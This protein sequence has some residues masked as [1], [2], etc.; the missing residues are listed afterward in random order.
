MR[1]SVILHKYNNTLSEAFECHIGV[2]QGDSLSTLILSLYV[3]DL[4]D[5]MVLNGCKGR[6]IGCL[7]LFLERKRER[8]REKGMIERYSG[9][10][11][12]K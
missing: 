5:Y 12:C 9:G 6:D 1:K 7:N 11:E 10:K 3:N 2:F 8:E 4:E